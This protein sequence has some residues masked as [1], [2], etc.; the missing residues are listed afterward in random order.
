MKD[1]NVLPVG[2]DTSRLVRDVRAALK[3]LDPLV[4][5]YIRQHPELCLAARYDQLE[6]DSER[7]DFIGKMIEAI[8]RGRESLRSP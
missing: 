1:A 6:A 5:A 2:D 7:D 3:D 8:C 4:L